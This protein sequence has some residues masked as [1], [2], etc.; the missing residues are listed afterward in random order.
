MSADWY[1]CDS[2]CEH[3][4]VCEKDRG[5][6]GLHDS[7]YCQ[8]DDARGLTKAEADVL[9]IQNSGAVGEAIAAIE[10]VL[11]AALGEPK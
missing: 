5:H 8:W 4:G 2:Y 10:G 7:G 11:R 1:P 3:G 6:D 9:L